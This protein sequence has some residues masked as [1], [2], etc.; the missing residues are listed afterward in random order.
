MILEH[1]QQIIKT[2]D[3][4]APVLIERNAYGTRP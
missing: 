1:G 2:R 3:D 4:N